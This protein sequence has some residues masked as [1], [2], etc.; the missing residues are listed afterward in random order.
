[1]ILVIGGRSKIGSALIEELG[2]KGER[3]RALARKGEGGGGFPQGLEV[4][5]GDL[6]DRASLRQ[7]MDGAD[8]VFL[9]CGPSEEEVELNRNAIDAARDAGIELLVRSSI[10]GSDPSSAATFVRDHGL[11]DAYVRESRVPHAILRPNL[12]MQ[13][14]PETTIPSIDAHGNFYANAG[15]AR[16]SMVD[17]R[18]VGAAAAALLTGAGEAGA[19]YDVS[20]PEALSYKEVADKLTSSLGRA[21][22]YVDAPDEAVRDTLLGY[23]LGDWLAGSLVDLLQD[24]KRSGTDGYAA[25][26]TDTVRQLT[27]RPPRSLD[28]LLAESQLS[29]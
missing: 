5:F 29:A 12:F 18:D 25:A 24:Y 8:R 16:I 20:G 28:Q 15:S 19:A 9:L 13:N 21:I 26:V 6:A 10:L 14:V 11:C 3:V 17:T 22:T 1:M 23:G 2:A 7:A 27:G 4:V